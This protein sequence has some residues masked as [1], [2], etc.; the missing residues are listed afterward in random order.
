MEVEG[1]K[2][3]ESIWREVSGIARR[4]RRA[5]GAGDDERGGS[6]AMPVK[7]YLQPGIAVTGEDNVE[8]WCFWRIGVEANN[9]NS[10]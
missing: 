9:S 10:R 1:R 6:G 4:F 5:G 8:G 7:R 3:S 2:V